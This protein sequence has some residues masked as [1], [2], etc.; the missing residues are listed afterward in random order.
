MTQTS[1]QTAWPGAPLLWEWNKEPELKL[2]L[3]IRRCDDVAVVA[4]K[5]RI[6]Y[7]NEVEALSCTV[8]DLLPQ[9]RQLVLE[10]SQ[11]ETVDGAGLGELLAL[12]AR[13][14]ERGC[15]IKLAAPSKA[16]REL[17]ELTRVASA[18]EI[19]A[20]VNDALGVAHA[21]AQAQAV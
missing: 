14:Q 15:T 2:S 18:F 12:L 1:S 11:V 5:G 7:G 8:A 6:V 17:L 3:E 19:H 20:T 16:V 4:C 13:A 10:L 21:H 9:S